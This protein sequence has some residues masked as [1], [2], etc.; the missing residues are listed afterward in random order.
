M[1][2]QPCDA[3]QPQRI[4]FKFKVENIPGE[5]TRRPITLVDASML[6]F[7]QRS[8]S[9][10]EDY[11]LAPSN[12]DHAKGSGFLVLDINKNYTPTP[13]VHNVPM[14]YYKVI[15]SEETMYDEAAHIIIY[16]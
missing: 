6:H 10:D 5:P 12:I 4:C 11:M 7:F 1:D 13:D 9:W 8:F 3:Q 2:S 16:D 14:S 15:P